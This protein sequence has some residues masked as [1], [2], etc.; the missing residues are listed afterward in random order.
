MQSVGNVKSCAGQVVMICMAR[1]KSGEVKR[2]LGIA[3]IGKST[4]KNSPGDKP[5][6]FFFV[7]PDLF[8]C[9]VNQCADRF[10]SAPLLVAQPGYLIGAQENIKLFHGFIIHGRPT[11]TR[12]AFNDG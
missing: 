11:Q 4:A 5:G 8:H 9:C 1:A 3:Q 2:R 7:V 12:R 10:T 6:L